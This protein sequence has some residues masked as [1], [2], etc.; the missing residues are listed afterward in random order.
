MKECCVCLEKIHFYNPCFLSCGHVFHETC[1]KQWFQT[2][3]TC[4]YCRKNSSILI[5]SN[6]VQCIRTLFLYIRFFVMMFILSFIYEYSFLSMT[7]HTISMFMYFLYTIYHFVNII[8]IFLHIVISYKIAQ[9]MFRIPNL[10]IQDHI[11]QNL[12][13]NLFIQIPHFL[14]L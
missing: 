10:P 12:F 7:N 1:I 5:N 2:S 4:P 9:K 6:P 13:L 8:F 14:I 3:R 11:E